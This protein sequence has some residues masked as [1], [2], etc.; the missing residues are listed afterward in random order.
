MSAGVEAERLYILGLLPAILPLFEP[1]PEGDRA[2]G[3]TERRDR[4]LMISS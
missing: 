1:E 4:V 3:R 2:K